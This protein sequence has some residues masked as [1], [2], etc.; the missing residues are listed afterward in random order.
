MWYFLADF[1]SYVTHDNLRQRRACRCIETR[2][3]RDVSRSTAP[4]H[5]A[6]TTTAAAAARKTTFLHA[7]D[8]SARC[9]VMTSHLS[10]DRHPRSSHDCV[11]VRSICRPPSLKM[12]ARCKQDVCYRG[13]VYCKLVLDVFALNRSVFLN[14][15]CIRRS[16]VCFSLRHFRFQISKLCSD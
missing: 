13:T 2:R 11:H 9:D 8:V 3:H 4:T 10:T 1:R 7:V 16:F 12:D 14:T 6:S 5:S 15:N